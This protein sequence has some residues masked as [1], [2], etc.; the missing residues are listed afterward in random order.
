M[1]IAIALVVAVLASYYTTPWFGVPFALLLFVTLRALQ[2]L[3]LLYSR[4]DVGSYEHLRQIEYQR[5]TYDQLGLT[6]PLEILMAP[7]PFPFFVMTLTM[8][9]LLAVRWFAGADNIPNS[10]FFTGLGLGL[11]GMWFYAPA[12]GISRGLGFIIGAISIAGPT[13]A[14]VLNALPFGK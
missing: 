11:F 9:F 8:M 10:M 12:V 13:G 2:F 7:K 5:R 3:A 1:L 14:Y 4:E 6:P